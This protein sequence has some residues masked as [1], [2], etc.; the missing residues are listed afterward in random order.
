MA[1]APSVVRAQAAPASPAAR[2][3]PTPADPRKQCPPPPLRPYPPRPVRQR[4]WHRPPSLPTTARNTCRRRPDL[5]PATAGVDVRGGDTPRRQSARTIAT[6]GRALGRRLHDAVRHPVD[7][8]DF[9]ASEAAQS[10]RHPPSR[11]RGRKGTCWSST[12]LRRE[13]LNGAGLALGAWHRWR[14][15]ASSWQMTATPTPTATP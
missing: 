6:Q 11:C 3:Q 15:A 13:V 12:S 4:K 10:S 14:S 5:P 2:P 9:S 8:E 7:W 1:F